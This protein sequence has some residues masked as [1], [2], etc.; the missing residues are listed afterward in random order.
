MAE[1]KASFWNWNLA[2]HLS[3]LWFDNMGLGKGVPSSSV[4][5]LTSHSVFTM[6]VRLEQGKVVVGA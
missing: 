2:S 3:Q 4:A 5:Y 6:T 1:R